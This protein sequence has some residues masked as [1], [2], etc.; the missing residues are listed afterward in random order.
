M[1]TSKT[2]F[3]DELVR[4]GA[5]MGLPDDAE[6]TQVAEA[7]TARLADLERQVRQFDEVREA[8]ARTQA[9][10]ALLQ[11]DARDA[12]QRFAAIA[13]TAEKARLSA[14]PGTLV[15]IHLADIAAKAAPR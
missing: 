3:K 13:A 8:N 5:L 10:N 6:P 15:F 11:A 2:P 14:V 9:A 7:V 1:A 12:A 4:I